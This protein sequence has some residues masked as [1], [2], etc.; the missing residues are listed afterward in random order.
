MRSE[1]AREIKF[2]A[3]KRLYSLRDLGGIWESQ[4]LIAVLNQNFG[5]NISDWVAFAHTRT[6]LRIRTGEHEPWE[7]QTLEKLSEGIRDMGDQ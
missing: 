6:Y 5:W 4:K 1:Q 7:V 2:S 3:E